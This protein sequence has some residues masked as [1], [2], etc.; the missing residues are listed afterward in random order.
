[1]RPALMDV[2]LLGWVEGVQLTARLRTA[3]ARPWRR[4]SWIDLACENTGLLA[5]G[6]R[7][8]IWVDV[9]EKW[10]ANGPGLIRDSSSELALVTW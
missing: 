8:C 3:S 2:S 10:P 9:G 1:M 5:S 4:P 6:T 7:K